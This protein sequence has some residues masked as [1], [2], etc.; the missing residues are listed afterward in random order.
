M[1]YLASYAVSESVEFSAGFDGRD[2]QIRT[3]DGF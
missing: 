2:V 1:H 3:M